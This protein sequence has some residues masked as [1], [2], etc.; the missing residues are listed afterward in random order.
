VGGASAHWRWASPDIGT[1]LVRKVNSGK[2]ATYTASDAT[3]SRPR[4]PSR[5]KGTGPGPYP[6]LIGFLLPEI[7]VLLV[8][9]YFVLK[10][11]EGNTQDIYRYMRCPNCTQKLRF[12]KVQ[13]GSVGACSRCKKPFLF[14]EGTLRETELDAHKHE[15]FT[16]ADD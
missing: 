3:E 14:P 10:P 12:R 16:E 1:S 8:A 4:S 5:M 15:E 6:K 13:V 2:N 7:V 9:L 11:R